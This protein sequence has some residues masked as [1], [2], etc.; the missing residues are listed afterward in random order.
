MNNVVL[1]FWPKNTVFFVVVFVMR[2]HSLLT[3]IIKKRQRN[4][5]IFR[6]RRKNYQTKKNYAITKVGKTNDILLVL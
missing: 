6:R 4:I 2:V 1:P 5:L 3:L